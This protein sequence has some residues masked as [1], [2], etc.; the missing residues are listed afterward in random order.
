[1]YIFHPLETHEPLSAMLLLPIIMLQLFVILCQFG[2]C[3]MGQ[4]TFTFTACC[5][6]GQW[7]RVG[8]PKGGPSDVGEAVAD[9][10]AKDS[11]KDSKGANDAKS[12]KKTIKK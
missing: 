12:N 11:K 7:V 2:F 10:L 5:F 9:T 3:Y 8:K 4:F 6:S 1:M